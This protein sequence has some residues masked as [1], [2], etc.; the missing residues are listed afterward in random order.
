MPRPSQDHWP[1][2][3]EDCPAREPGLSHTQDGSAYCV[4]CKEPVRAPTSSEKAAKKP[5]G[6]HVEPSDDCPHCEKT[7]KS[8]RKSYPRKA[9]DGDEFTDDEVRRLEFLR[10]LRR[11]GRL[12]D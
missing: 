9:E 6:D 8:E 10:G 7:H 5:K 1:S 4:H 12:K 11:E 2:R 3:D